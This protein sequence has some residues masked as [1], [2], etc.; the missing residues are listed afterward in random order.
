MRSLRF[1]LSS[2]LV[3]AVLAVA[4][5]RA[6]VGFSVLAHQAVIDG[7][8]E[9]TIVPRLRQRF[10]RATPADLEDARAYAYGGSHVSDLGY[11]PL[12]NRLFSE[13]MHYVRTGDFVNELV[14]QASTP[15]EYAFALGALAHYTADTIG[16]PGA[17]NRAVASI[18]PDLAEE[19]GEAV[20][21]ADSPS[22]H[23]QTEFRFDVLEVV[24]RGEIPDLYDHAVGFE[25]PRPLLESVFREVY[26]LDLDD[27]FVSYEVALGTYR[28][29]FRALL[30]EATGIA[31]NLYEDDIK[32]ANPRVRPD[33]FVYSL[34]RADFEKQFGDTYGEPGYFARFLAFFMGLVPNV[35]PFE[36]LPYKPLPPAVQRMYRDAVGKIS[37]TY[38]ARLVQLGRGR[39][40]LPNLDLDSGQA[41]QAGEYELAD[42]VY[43]DLLGRLA[44]RKFEGVSREAAAKLLAFYTAPGARRIAEDDDGRETLAAIDELRSIANAA[45]KR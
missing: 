20:R 7:A 42:E 28:W 3:G 36:R 18:F 22:A 1:V 17:T 5:P 27:L 9:S 23:L 10:P 37:K 41:S 39:L 8:W 21:Y 32:R 40:D 2:L 19:H 44:D 25:V 31:W 11:F 16:H 15:Q 35:G 43:A 45:G 34:S 38:R 14:E 13:L 30:E 33:D 29:A 26:G 12:G 4:W 24:R 6:A